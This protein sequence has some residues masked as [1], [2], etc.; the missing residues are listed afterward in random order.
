MTL[1]LNQFASIVQMETK[2]SA[3]CLK[4]VTYQPQA[5]SSLILASPPLSL[6]AVLWE[7]YSARAG[8]SFPLFMVLPAYRCC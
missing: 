5:P 1:Y 8:D 4:V 7:F 3:K 6:I 2:A